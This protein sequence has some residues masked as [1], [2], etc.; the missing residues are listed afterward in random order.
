[1]S[2]VN[3]ATEKEMSNV[4]NDSENELELKPK[5]SDAKLAAIRKAQETRKIKARERA[6]KKAE[7][8]AKKVLERMEKKKK[9]A[10]Q[11][12]LPKQPIKKKIIYVSDTD[13]SEQENDSESDEEIIVKRKPKKEVLKP[14]KPKRKIQQ[15]DDIKQQEQ[16]QRLTW[17]S[18][19]WA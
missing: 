10:E 13:E 15:I 7:E 1:M 17:D 3:E 6:E 4:E 9:T 2:T 16:P 5:I 18:I 14:T 19:R 8:D 12:Q 11:S